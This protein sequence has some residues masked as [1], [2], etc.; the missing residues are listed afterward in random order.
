MNTQDGRKLAVVTGASKGIGFELARQCVDHGF[1]VLIC[2]D[3][4]EIHR[5][6]SELSDGEVEVEAVQADLATYDGCQQLLDAVRAMGRPVDALLL[7]AGIGVGGEFVATDL[8]DELRTIGLNCAAVVHLAKGI[9]PQMAARGSGRV[10]VTAS[11]ASTAPAPFLA[12]YGATKAFDLSF[13]EAL[14]HE[15]E[16]T[17]VTV[18]ALQPGATDTEFFERADMEDTKVA[19]GKKDDPAEV[20]RIGFQAM[21]KGEDSVVAASLRSRAQGWANEVLPEPTKAR[22]QS[23]QTEP[24]SAR[25][26]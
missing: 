13:A 5:A 6:A 2:A 19:Q 15:L 17:G 25:G 7:N 23:K 3:R 12:V 22:I 1:D 9:V 20:A 11:I 21:M 14:R 16:D 24:G 10:L 26:S 8:D 4:E 18:T